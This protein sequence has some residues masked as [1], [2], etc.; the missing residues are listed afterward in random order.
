MMIGAKRL[1]QLQ[2]DLLATYNA[3]EQQIRSLHPGCEWGE[4]KLAGLEAER[5]KRDQVEQLLIQ[6]LQLGIPQGPIA[7]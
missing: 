4:W 5:K 6:H 2:L 3:I 7:A 1:E